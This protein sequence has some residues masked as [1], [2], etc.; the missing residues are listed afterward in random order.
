MNKPQ[1]DALFR[2]Y[3]IDDLTDEEQTLFF[4]L[5]QDKSTQEELHMAMENWWNETERFQDMPMDAAG[6]RR[7]RQVMERISI[8]EPRKLI[9]PWWKWVA[10]ACIALVGFYV[11]KA[12]IPANEPTQHQELAVIEIA[13]TYGQKK[14]VQLPDG[15]VIHLN[16]GSMIQYDGNFNT[17]MRRLTLV[18][19]AFFEVTSNP[20]KPFIVKTGPLYAKVLGTSFNIR[21]MEN[22]P[23]IQVVVAGGAVQVGESADT[24]ADTIVHAVLSPRQRLTYDKA[25]KQVSVD[26][27]PVVDRWI[28]WKDGLLVFENQSFEE[29]AAALERWYNV[30][31]S[32]QNRLLKGCRFTGEFANLPLDNVLDMLQKSSSF[33]YQLKGQQVYINGKGCD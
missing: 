11:M 17:A 6:Q 29:I 30:R 21:A 1:F 20:E 14:R 28:S 5:L 9:R 25:S 8:P 26:E 12:Y 33:T 3:I 31:I 23:D 16:A 32:F 10:A 13:T 22:A 4:L 18:G 15:S 27:V 2:R 7:I 19:E 24:V